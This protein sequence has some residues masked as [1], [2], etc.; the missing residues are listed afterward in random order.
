MPLLLQIFTDVVVVLKVGVLEDFS[1]EPHPLH[2][3][4]I[5]LKR[6]TSSSSSQ[7]DQNNFFFPIFFLPMFF[8]SGRSM[9]HVSSNKEAF[10]ASKKTVSD[11]KSNTHAHLRRYSPVV[12][13]FID[14][15]H[16]LIS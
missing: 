16:S 5:D 3:E 6:S 13:T 11:S 4:S 8:Y 7:Q 12:R 14:I 2:T 15:M 9:T 10:E 1:T